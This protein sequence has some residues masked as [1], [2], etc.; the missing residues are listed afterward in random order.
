ML[1]ALFTISTV[2]YFEYR[3]MFLMKYCSIPFSLTIGPPK[4]IW[5]S[6]L[7]SIQLGKGVQLLCGITGFKFLP[8][9]IKAL[10][11]LALANI[12]RWIYCLRTK[13]LRKR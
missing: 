6:S 8:I 11:S 2:G 5:I 1:D 3:S 9:F 7:G 13:C 10:H 12:S 4:S